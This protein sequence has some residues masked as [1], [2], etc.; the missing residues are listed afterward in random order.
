M[1][2]GQERILRRRIRSVQS[3]KKITRAMELIAASRIVKAQ[4]RVAAA[5]PYADRITD[6]ARHL[7]ES[8]G[9]SHPLLSPRPEIRNVALVVIGADRGLCGGYNSSVIRAAE[10]EIREHARAGRGYALVTAGR[11]VEG[12]FRFRNYRIRAAHSG[13]S[14]NPSYED[15][16]EIAGS[17]LEPFEAGEFD[18]VQTVYTRF[19]SAGRQ[20][21][22]VRP[23][24][25]LDR[26]DFEGGRAASSAHSAGPGAG[27]S[28]E[29][30]AA[31]EFEPN[32]EAI[33][34]E[35]LPRYAQARVYAAL[36]NAAASEHAARQRAMKAA[37]DNADEL[38]TALSRVMNRARQDAITTEIM[39]IVGGAEALQADQGE[40]DEHE[41]FD[42][43]GVRAALTA[44][45][46][47]H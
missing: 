1:A 33:L 2:G 11:K 14:G 15:A 10:A 20:E 3:T 28:D 5:V 23:L 25:P 13:F 30:K 47:A 43:G 40:H 46:T 34:D 6:V 39:E 17:L 31:Y 37:T 4:A 12:Y 7:Q 9:S 26:E 22:V 8:G 42:F 45:H 35:L 27:G 29:Q 38:I 21:V 24:L 44:G 36:L 18:L 41:R 16:R 32:P 19:I